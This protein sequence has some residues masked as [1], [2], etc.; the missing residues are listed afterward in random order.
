MK[1][2]RVDEPGCGTVLALF[3]IGMALY[4][5]II[6]AGWN[7]TVPVIFGGPSIDWPQAFGLG[8]LIM[9]LRGIFNR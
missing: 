1:R 7:L 3:L 6:F 5:L 8:L 2:Y 4:T 9:V